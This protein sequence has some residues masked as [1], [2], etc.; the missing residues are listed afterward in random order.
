MAKKSSIL[1]NLLGLEP[2]KIDNVIV[3]FKDPDQIF[4]AGLNDLNQIPALGSSDIE[5]ILAFRNSKD[6]DQELEL[7][8]KE[9][10]DCLDIFDE[11]YPDL[12]R[13]IANPPLV[14]YIKGDRGVLSKFSFAIVGSRNP[15]QYG[16]SMTAEF[17]S[18][19]SALGIV[20]ISGLARGI[21]TIAHVEAL[22]NGET[23]A[24]LGS[25]LLNVYP[26][27]N[28]DL[29][30]R[31]SQKGAVISE[32]SLNSSPLKE[33]FPRRNRIVSGLSKGILVVEAAA[34]SGA[35]ITARLGC[36]QNREVFALPGNIDSP[37]S[38]GTHRLIKEGAK[39]VDS[40][41]DILEELNINV[42][43]G[44]DRP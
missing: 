24:V 15:T 13:Q 42:G 7:I 23:I 11:D 38:K 2:K 20:I 40:L 6:L 22:K 10:I 14:L 17:S 32:F 16:L 41:E 21:D 3:A 9:K 19:L 12:L 31:I 5:K 36:E 1:L 43:A 44:H 37:L 28:R 8:N 39:L 34:R 25:G 29:A 27:E 18:S 30:E 4:K 35:L 33:N 26:R